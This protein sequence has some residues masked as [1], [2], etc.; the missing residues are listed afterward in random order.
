MIQSQNSFLFSLF[1]ALCRATS[2]VTCGLCTAFALAASGQAQPQHGIAMYG[3]PVLPQDFVSLPYANPDAPKGGSI[4]TG[5]VGTFDSLNPFVRKGT[6]PWQLRFMAAESLMGRSWDEPFA[7]YGLLAESIET[8]PDRSWV[9]FKLRAEA[10][11]SDGSPV[12]VED[13]LWSYE[14]LGT[15]GDPR[16]RS[17]WA[18]VETAEQTGPRSVKFTFSS[19][20]RELALIAGLRP[21]LKKAQ[22]AGKDFV[23]SGLDEILV[24]SAPYVIGDFK[25]G[26]YISL[27]RNPEYWGKDLN[28]RRGTMNFDEVRFEFFGNGSTML[29]AF[30]AGVLTFNREFNVQKWDT[31]YN[32]PAVQ[33]GDVIKS[34]LPHQRPSGMTGFAMN[35]RRALFADWRVRDALIHAFNFEFINEAVTGGQQGRITSYF[36]N[37]PLAMQPGPAEGLVADYL[38][39]YA[40]QS[41]PGLLEGYALPVS[42]GSEANRANLRRA[43]KLLADAGY[44]VQDDGTLRSPDGAPVEIQMLLKQGS[45]ELLAVVD[46]YRKALERLGIDLVVSQID[47]AQYSERLNEYDYDMTY[48]RRGLSLSPG[49]EQY[50]YWGMEAAD[51]PGGR[52][53]IG[54]NSP[55]V[56]AMIDK[57]LTSTRQDEFLAAT[58]ALDRLLTTGRYVIPIYQWNVSR[59]A[60]AKE[61]KFPSN[62]PIYGDYLEWQPNVWWHEPTE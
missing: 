15:I 44:E 17:F 45:A 2:R 37:S 10:R 62:L 36:S 6:V 11:F 57:I 53:W 25:A 27:K 32:F 59:I 48:F 41:P 42:D 51:T 55:A 28:F 30:K 34:V 60:Y 13:V 26:R 19:E 40:D 54:V 33:S 29:E 20:N 56:D 49:N 18:Q 22:W 52:N 5:E 12:T 4:I 23:Q 50:L 43:R 35:T 7:L 8:P 38:T 21:I 47:A 24:S 61:L 3:D 58:Q 39:E 9:E 31:Q 16:Y 14:T 1:E 46:I